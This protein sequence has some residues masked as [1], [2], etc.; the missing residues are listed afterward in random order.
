MFRQIGQASIPANSLNSIAL[1]S[2]TGKAA[3]G[4]RLPRPNTADPSVT[5][6]TVL[7]LPVKAYAL[8]LSFAMAC[9]TRPTP[10]V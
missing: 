9:E 3:S 10:G 5:T 6:A 1:P 7:L 8:V 2:M 4:P